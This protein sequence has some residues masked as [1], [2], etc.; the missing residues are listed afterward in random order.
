MKQRQRFEP[1]SQLLFFVSLILL[2]SVAFVVGCSEDEKT[3]NVVVLSNRVFGCKSYGEE[4][5]SYTSSTESFGKECIVCKG[6]DGGLLY[7]RHENV[8]YNCEPDKIDIK[9]TINGQIITL[10]EEEINPKGNCTCPYDLE[11]TI[12]G[13]SNGKYTLEVYRNG[14]TSPY[15]KFSFN[16]DSK[17]K[18]IY[19]L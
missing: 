11:C 8:F 4:M 2:V 10:T 1:W 12:G 14:D 18:Q 5:T 13:L 3:S 9:V 16:F 19:N 17:F 15:A 7:I 6:S